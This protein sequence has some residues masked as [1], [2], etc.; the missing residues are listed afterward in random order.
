M[1]GMSALHDLKSIIHYDIQ[2]SNVLMRV[3]DHKVAVAKIANF[4]VAMTIKILR[5]IVASAGT[6]AWIAPET[7][8]WHV[9]GNE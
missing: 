4:G 7:F 9:L 3:A 8:D 6:L 1:T 5:S 2:T